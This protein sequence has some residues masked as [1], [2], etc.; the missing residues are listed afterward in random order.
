MWDIFSDDA[1]QLWTAWHRL[2]K[3]T[4]ELPLPTHRYLLNDIVD[5]YH[6]KKMIIRRFIN[7]SLKISS[8]S[9]PH[10]ALLHHY[11]CRDWRSTYGRNY[12]NICREAGVT[13]VSQVDLHNINVNPVP[14]GE[15]WRVGLLRDL[16][17][18]RDVGPGFLTKE[19]IASII[20]TVC[21]D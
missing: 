9:N 11:Q 13:E 17:S 14:P 4:Y 5:G 1:V 18:E 2:I 8:S 15:E 21:C 19:D 6:L 12:M 7:F 16:L 20:K 3:Y 10:V